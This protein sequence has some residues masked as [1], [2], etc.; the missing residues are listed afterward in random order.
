VL[1]DRPNS[2][3]SMIVAGRVLPVKGTQKRALD[4]ANEVLGGDFPRA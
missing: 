4:L 1:I 3:Q 2:P